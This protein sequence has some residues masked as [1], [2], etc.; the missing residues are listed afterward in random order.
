M[1]FVYSGFVWLISLGMIVAGRGYIQ[2]AKRM[3]G[4][5]TTRARILARKLS[6]V[7]QT[8]EGHWGKGGGYQPTP[9]YE[10]VVDGVTYTSDKASYALKG[11]KQSVAEADLAAIPD[12]IDVHYDPASPDVVYRELHT[13]RLGYWLIGGGIIGVLIGLIMLVPA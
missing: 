4:F 13:P 5:R 6:I 11:R 1:M 12:E 3:R 10:Y 7:S 2:L 9:T 8:T